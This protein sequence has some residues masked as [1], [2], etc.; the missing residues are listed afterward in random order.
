MDNKGKKNSSVLKIESP[1]RPAC[2][3]HPESFPQHTRD[4]RGL[5]AHLDAAVTAGEIT[6][7]P[8]S[9]ICTF[10]FYT[11]PRANQNL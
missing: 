8:H 5:E 7:H 1:S 11:K 4:E 10:R 9:F 3:R 6:G 2:L